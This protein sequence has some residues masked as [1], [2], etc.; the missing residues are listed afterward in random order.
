MKI[1]EAMKRCKEL[2]RKAEDYRSKIA[3]NCAHLSFETPLYGDRQREQVTEW[4]QG[5]EGLMREV[6]KLRVAIQRTN[7]AVS[8]PIEIDGKTVTKT[9]AEWVHRR[10][11]LAKLDQQ[12]WAMLTDRNLQEGKAKNSQGGPDLDIIIVRDYDPAQRDAKVE[13]YRS[14]PMTIDG[15]LEVVNAV[16]DLVE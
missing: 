11:D 14:E 3:A 9:I 5:H 2:M 8:V 13:L 1:I 4:V 6:L 10:R 7:L 15:T 16:T 12:A